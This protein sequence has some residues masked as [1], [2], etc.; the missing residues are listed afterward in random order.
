MMH[1]LKH[2][3]QRSVFFSLEMAYWDSCRKARAGAYFL[4]K[5][6]SQVQLWAMKES[7]MLALQFSGVL[8]KLPFPFIFI[9]VH[10]YFMNSGSLNC[11]FLTHRMIHICLFARVS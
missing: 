1:W 2:K 3:E 10:K 11:V 7:F 6:E 5:N 8:H 9:T 4:L